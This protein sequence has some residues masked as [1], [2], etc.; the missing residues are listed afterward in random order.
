MN[1]FL[2]DEWFGAALESILQ[3]GEGYGGG[4]AEPAERIQVELV[5]ANPTRVAIS[6]IGS[7]GLVRRLFASS[8]RRCV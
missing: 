4:W 5:S 7:P 1:L 3:A 2:A 6:V 8:M